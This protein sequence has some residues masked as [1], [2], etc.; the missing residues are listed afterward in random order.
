MIVPNNLNFLFCLP[1]TESDFLS[2]AKNID[3]HFVRVHLL[4]S[5]EIKPIG[6]IW[7]NYHSQIVNPY[8]AFRN[9]FSKYGFH[10]SDRA[11]LNRFAHSIC[12]YDVN[13]IFGHCAKIDEEK[14]EF[15][16]QLVNINQI[17]DV[18]PI[19]YNNVID[20]SVCSPQTISMELK[21][22]RTLYDE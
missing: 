5:A 12:N 11:T 16:D 18:I 8:L 9:E 14:L 7:E 17:I 10:F 20:L 21:A 3:K 4:E 22:K 6:A 1:L 19:D 2:D 13:I 15:Y